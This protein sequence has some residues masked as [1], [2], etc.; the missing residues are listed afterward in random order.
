MA[1][2]PGER[3]FIPIESELQE[4][5]EWFIRLR[6]MAGAGILAGAWVLDTFIL[7]L[8]INSLP[9]YLVGVAVLAYNL[10]F[11]CLRSQSKQRLRL[12]KQSLSAQIALDWIA[13]ISLVHYTGGIW[14]PVAMAFIFHIII[15]AILL[16]RQAC[17]LLAAFAALLL[18]IVVL[19]EETAVWPPVLLL[20]LRLNPTQVEVSGFF[21]WAALAVI[22]IVTAFLATSI[23]TRLREKEMALSQ[24]EQ[25]LIRAYDEMAKLYQ[26][27][28]IVNS[29]L[30]FKETLGLIAENAAKLMNMKACFI[31]LFDDTGKKLYIGGSYGLSDDYINKGPVEV[32]K[33][34]IDKETLA[35][36]V[37]QVLDVAEDLRFQY[38]EEARREGLHS[39]L[40]VPVSL[41]TRVLGVIR[42][43]S[44]HPHHFQES[45]QQLLL[46]LANLGATAIANAR[47]YS[48]LQSLN[49]QRVWFARMTHHQL[50]TPL[51][52]IR[53]ILDAL[54]YAGELNEK[55]RELIERCSRRVQDAF[56]TIRDLLDLAAAQRPLEERP[57]EAVD[58][59]KSL[60]DAVESARERAGEK[61]V[62]FEVKM[63]DSPI[64]VPVPAADINRIFSNLL[65]NAVKY[66][67]SGGKVTFSVLREKENIFARILDTGIG[68]PEE[69]Q[70]KIFEGFYRTQK[71]KAT[72]EI[73][74][75]LGLSIVKKLTERW[76]L[77]LELESSPGSGTTFTVTIPLTRISHKFA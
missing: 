20:E 26:L 43:Y 46:N 50:R 21:L 3:V 12:L 32:E 68:I 27:G 10:I 77:G 16:S 19:F 33:S 13:L 7:P 69:E 66:T 52:A 65:D 4:R 30:D 55:Q 45:E 8:Q 40:C 31:R 71:A 42:V 54:P 62:I 35:G 41:G 57:P 59:K 64:E 25:A 76:Q 28:Q 60:K 74:T 34:L 14:S 67:P 73:G 9:L 29:T 63:P 1:Q 24:S 17:Y 15:G 23:T 49:E 51:A 44:D 58:F 75:G 11:H 39:V 18:G 38:R 56:D 37:V 47:S 36:G 5:L 48:D 61:G 22:L 2:T 53:A 72:G 6:W 70:E